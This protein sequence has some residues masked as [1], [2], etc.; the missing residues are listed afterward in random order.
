[1]DTKSR[2]YS[3][4]ATI[5]NGQVASSSNKR[6]CTEPP[7]VNGLVDLQRRRGT[8]LYFYELIY[9][10]LI[11]ISLLFFSFRPYAHVRQYF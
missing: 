4:A 10:F 8:L 7:F 1:M 11:V 9:I 6:T 5:E 3:K 2:I